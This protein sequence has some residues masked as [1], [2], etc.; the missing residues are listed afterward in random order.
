MLLLAIIKKKV[1]RTVDSNHE[2]PG[3]NPREGY[4]HN[5][6]AK[7]FNTNFLACPGEFGYLKPDSER[8]GQNASF[9]APNSSRAVMLPCC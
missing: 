7:D 4:R 5:I 9:L 2:V 3:S 6:L 8:Y 1:V